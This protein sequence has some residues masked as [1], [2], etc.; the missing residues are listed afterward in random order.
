MLILIAVC[1][2]LTLVIYIAWKD[3]E[4]TLKMALIGGGLLAGLYFILRI[5]FILP[6]VMYLLISFFAFYLWYVVISEPTI[7]NFLFIYLCIGISTLYQNWKGLVYAYVLSL[8]SGAHI[9]YG[10][11]GDII[12]PN[13][14]PDQFAF[15]GF[16]LSF[17][18][19]IF[20]FHSR[21]FNQTEKAREKDK[22]DLLA[23]HKQM[24]NLLADVQQVIQST[25]EFSKNV[26]T[27][28]EH[29]DITSEDVIQT[30]QQMAQA[31][32]EQT[33][34]MQGI[35]TSMNI[36]DNDVKT[37]NVDVLQTT[38]S[39]TQTL[40]TV[41]KAKHD[42]N[43]LLH[44]MDEL[45]HIFDDNEETVN[46]LSEH[47]NQIQT[48]IKVISDIAEQTNLLSL[49]A[50]IESARAGEAGKGFHVVSDEI[51][52]LSI[53]SANNT[54]EIAKI[55]KEFDADAKSAV[56]KTLT[57]KEKIANNKLST[58]QVQ[59]AFEEIATNNE[60]TA[61]SQ[62]NVADRMHNLKDASTDIVEEVNNVSAIS[63]QN[64]A[65]IEEVLSQV[66]VMKTLITDTK[67]N[68]EEVIRQLQQ[69]IR[70]SEQKDMV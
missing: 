12:F 53:Q 65:S 48:I 14:T 42:V 31:M 32:D 41:E 1:W 58:L 16:S 22:Q 5:R 38:N 46:R 45:T 3:Y 55:L 7:T 19:G 43:T 20:L 10:K 59:R 2:I 30:V 52:K 49:N 18:T 66:E 57:S 54:K 64:A 56:Q 63:E 26:S 70:I 4:K 67:V 37:M 27:I 33:I 15:I 35:N 51:K 47:S 60:Q 40:N 11:T 29:T 28:V 25:N 9:F 17:L 50:A 36:I 62:Q 44:D 8:A 69:L 61:S 39:S 34:S 6:Y 23:S 13:S 24:E 68:Y 21:V